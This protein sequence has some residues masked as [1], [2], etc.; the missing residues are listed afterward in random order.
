MIWRRGAFTDFVFHV[1]LLRLVQVD[2]DE[3]AAV[4]FDP[5]PLA[6]DLA[7]EH[8]VLQDGVVD[9]GQSTAGGGAN[10]NVRLTLNQSQPGRNMTSERG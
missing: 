7:G 5:D 6:H 4:Q 2:L 3:P 10:G 1:V 8:Q 9:R